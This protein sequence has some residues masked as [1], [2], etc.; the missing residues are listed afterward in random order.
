MEQS[1]RV[2]V[3]TGAASGIGFSLASRLI[4]QNFAVVMVDNNEVMLKKSF[5]NLSYQ[6]NVSLIPCVCDISK[7]SDVERLVSLTYQHFPHVNYLFNNAGV[8]GPLAPVWSLKLEE[9]KHTMNVNVFGTVN[10][11]QQFV[12]RLINQKTS[13]HIINIGSVY[14]LVSSSYMSAYAMSKHALLA[15]S[16]SLLFDLKREGHPIDVSI[17]LPSFVNTALLDGHKDASTFQAMMQKLLVMG[18]SAND[19][20]NHIL[21]GVV[22]K[23][24]YILPDRE[25]KTYCEERIAAI[26]SQK[27]PF[28]HALQKM[29]HKLI[30]RATLL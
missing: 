5:E 15:L 11:I 21:N 7:E 22:D 27:E 17:V 9:I 25:A 28:E 18:R 19:V 12:P 20:A 1:I 8:S 26:L 29:A 3:V 30:L 13:A 10:C 14:S 6:T 2:A 24:F 4:E 16:E 23:Q